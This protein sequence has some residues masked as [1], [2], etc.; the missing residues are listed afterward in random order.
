MFA[1]YGSGIAAGC[2]CLGLQHIM[3]RHWRLSPGR[4]TWWRTQSWKDTLIIVKP[5]TL[6]R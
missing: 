2:M 4:T 5:D 3:G 1:A 6:L